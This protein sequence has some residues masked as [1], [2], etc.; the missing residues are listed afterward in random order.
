MN[1][2]SAGEEERE[3]EGEAE[4]ERVQLVTDSVGNESSQFAS[5]IGELAPFAH[6]NV[7]LFFNARNFLAVEDS[8]GALWLG[9]KVFADGLSHLEFML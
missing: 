9:K 4:R 7:C 2:L 5:L 8:A 1:A 6:L 3:R